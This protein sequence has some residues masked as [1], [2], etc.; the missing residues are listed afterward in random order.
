MKSDEFSSM[1]STKILRNTFIEHAITFIRYHGF[2]G[3]DLGF[4]YT[5]HSLL[6]YLKLIFISFLFKDW[7]FP[8][9]IKN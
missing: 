8:G 3:I 2:D 5:I 7:E 6:I 9:R 1:V 4:K